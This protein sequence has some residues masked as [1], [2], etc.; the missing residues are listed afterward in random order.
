MRALSQNL[1]QTRS[2]DYCDPFDCG[3]PTVQDIIQI[4]NDRAGA[5]R[6]STRPTQIEGTFVRFVPAVPIALLCRR[7]IDGTTA[8]RCMTFMACLG[9]ASPSHNGE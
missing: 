5:A 1:D 3:S 9:A 7:G 6:G 2:W 4:L 8:S